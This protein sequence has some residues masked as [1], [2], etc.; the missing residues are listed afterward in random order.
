MAGS[1]CFNPFFIDSDY[2]L[3]SAAPA[4]L[5]GRIEA[6]PSPGVGC[7]CVPGFL[8]QRGAPQSPTMAVPEVLPSAKQRSSAL[9]T[10]Q[11]SLLNHPGHTRRY[12][13]LCRYRHRRRKDR[14]TPLRSDTVK[15]I[16]P[17]I[18]EQGNVANAPLFPS[19]R[20][21]PLSRDAVERIVARHC[22]V[23][24]ET[25]PTLKGKKVTPHALRH[26]LGYIFIS[27]YSLQPTASGGIQM[28]FPPPA[29][30]LPDIIRYLSEAFEE[31][32]K[33][34]RRPITSWITCSRRRS[35][36]CLLFHCRCRL[37]IDLGGLGALM[38]EPECDDRAV[39]AGLQEFHCAGVSI[40]S[41]T[42]LST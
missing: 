36:E 29:F 41:C 16:E 40:M 18:H 26:Y 13:R 10:T 39:D 20:G 12:R 19:N 4:R 6:L 2:L 7:T 23:A 22:R 38:P 15:V 27:G 14:A 24:S 11:F 35:G 33:T 17:W 9:R 21:G 34:V 5:P 32:E 3:S 42:R 37:D 31:G 30:I 8:R 1:D 25:C 28:E